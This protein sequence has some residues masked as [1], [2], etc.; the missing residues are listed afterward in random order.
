VGPRAG[1]HV[2]ENL[3]PNEI[4]SPDRPAR[5]QSLYRLSYPAH[6]HT[7][8]QRLK[9]TENK[10]PS[11]TTFSYVGTSMLHVSAQAPSH[12]QSRSCLKELLCRISYLLY[13]VYVRVENL[14][15]TENI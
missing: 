1:L 13:C 12:N 2:S 14:H 4:R 5:S 8:I 15:I 3:A 10:N 6:W 9:V 11:I 7:C